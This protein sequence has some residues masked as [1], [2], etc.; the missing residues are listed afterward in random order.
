MKLYRLCFIAILLNGSPA[1]AWE[2]QPSAR[3]AYHLKQSLTSTDLEV[4]KAATSIAKGNSLI[5]RS[6]APLLSK[7]RGDLQTAGIDL[8]QIA[9][10]RSI[11]PSTIHA[12]L[13]IATLL[14]EDPSQLKKV[15]ELIEELKNTTQSK[16]NCA[17]AKEAVKL[18]KSG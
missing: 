1:H 12:V 2:D 3:N 17:I 15:Q 11:D 13:A 8:S 18:H 10:T 14:E 5:V 6:L 7:P 4:K 9:S 16:E